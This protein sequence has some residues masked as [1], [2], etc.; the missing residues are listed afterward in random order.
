MRSR[1]QVHCVHPDRLHAV[2][3]CVAD[4][5]E[6]CVPENVPWIDPSR[7][8]LAA[9]VTAGITNHHTAHR[10][11]ATHQ[12]HAQLPRC[13]QSSKQTVFFSFVLRMCRHA[14]SQAVIQCGGTLT[15]LRRLTSQ[16]HSP[17]EYCTRICFP[18][19]LHQSPHRSLRKTPLFFEFA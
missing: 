17:R 10:R 3:S 11:N 1:T 18:Q 4:V 12:R 13:F 6:G 14:V 5:P 8:L 7:R 19:H 9:S 2:A 15:K 16:T